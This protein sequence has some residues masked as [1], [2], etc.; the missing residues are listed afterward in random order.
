MRSFVPLVVLWAVKQAPLAANPVIVYDNIPGILPP[1]IV[2]L[3]YQANQTA[4]FGGLVRFDSSQRNLMAAVIVLSDWAMASTWGSTDPGWYHPITLNLYN[5][6]ASSGTSRE[7]DCEQDADVLV[8]WRPEPDPSCPGGTA[9]RSSNG[10]CYNGLAFEVTFFFDGLL[11]PD[12]LIY[13]VAYNTNT[14][15]AHPIGQP[16]PTSR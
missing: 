3:G 12:Q 16:G 4:E 15:R 11:V 14:W 6:D 8:P 2:R 5:V 10:N 13:G 1:N 7:P 9:W